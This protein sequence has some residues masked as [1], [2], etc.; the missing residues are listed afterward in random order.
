[1]DPHQRIVYGLVNRCSAVTEAELCRELRDVITLLIR[2]TYRTPSGMTPL[3][4]P[5]REA[6]SDSLVGPQDM[7]NS[8]L[9]VVHTVRCSAKEIF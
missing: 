2:D 5:A 3:V 8:L 1:V 4:V 7:T 9:H 6:C